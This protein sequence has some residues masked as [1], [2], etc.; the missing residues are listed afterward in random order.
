[1]DSD[2]HKIISTN[3]SG[4]I[5]NEDREII[6]GNHV[7]IGCRCNILKGSIIPRGSIIASG[8]IISSK[9]SQEYAIYGGQGATV[10]IIRENTTW[11]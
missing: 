11:C 10:R 4:K 8:S 5:L 2:W 7:W 1:M 3:G 9:L 6:F